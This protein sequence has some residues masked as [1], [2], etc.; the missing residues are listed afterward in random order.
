MYGKNYKKKTIFPHRHSRIFYDFWWSQKALWGAIMQ[1]LKIEKD[2]FILV[3]GD[4]GCQPKG[5]KVL[6][7]DG[8]WKSIENIQIGDEVISPQKDGT[9][10]F[11]KVKWINQ[12]KCPETYD[13]IQNNKKHKKLY[14]CSNNHKIPFYHKF[15]KRGTDAEGKRYYIKNW[16]GFKDY[17]AEKI[18]NMYRESFSHQNIGFSSF[19]IKNFKNNKNCEIEPYTLGVIL[20]DGHYCKQLSITTKDKEIIKEIEKFYPVMSIHKKENNKAKGYMF[21]MNSKLARSLKEYNLKNKKSGNKFIPKEALLSDSKYRKRLLAGLINTDGYFS[22]GGYSYTSKSKDLIEDIKNLVYSLGGRCGEIRKVKKSIRSRNFIGEYY[23]ISFYLGNMKIPLLLNRKKRDISRIYLEQNRIA[24]NTKKAGEKIVYGFELDSES[25]WYITDNWM[26]TKN[27]G[28][29]HF[30]GTFCFKH[31][32]KEPNRVLN[33]GTNMFI[34]KENFI[35]DPDEFA[36][37]MITKEGQAIWL[38]EARRVANRR[39]W[40]SKINNAVADRKNQNRKLFNVY[41][42]CMPFEKEFDPT[43]ASHLTL[44]IWVRRGVCEIYCKRSGVK[45]GTGLNIQNILEREEK[46]LK[47][48]PKKTI[49][50][51]AIHPEYIGRIA[52]SKLSPKL[53]KKYNEL[54]KSKKATGDLTDE[55]KKRF[56]IVEEKT[57]ENLVQDAVEKIANKEI[58]D[59]KTLW[60]E[61][62]TLKIPDE[63]KIKMLN[64]YLQL[65]GFSTFGRL[66]EKK[67]IET[68]DVW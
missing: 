42:L 13:I 35:I 16:W 67:K 14:S 6:M 66:F 7:S 43:L 60:N 38:D 23:E 64:F 48:N 61:L 56:G 54:V 51:P 29:S 12:W 9:N 8:Y 65:E 44:W 52:F 30:T 26:V 40:F 2:A 18:N 45:G 53:E 63:K 1:R 36:Y 33:D 41:W 21:S 19:E 59:K 25:H 46:Y 10:K 11:S 34:A 68:E 39:K 37:K 58:K 22:N 15:Y 49:V 24:I 57:P 50:N 28:K 31:A 27:S 4:T 20:G 32:E 55:E 62:S 17:T 3:T 5:S 47:E